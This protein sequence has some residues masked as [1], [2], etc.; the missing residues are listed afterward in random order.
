MNSKLRNK[1][2]A[3]PYSIWMT[4]FIIIPLIFVVYYGLTNDANAFTLDNVISFFNPIHLKSF[5]QAFK[6]AFISTLICIV[7]AFPI[8]LIF[9][10]SK[11]KKSSFVVYVFILPMWMNGLLRIYAWLTLI[12]KKGVINLLLTALGLPNINIV[13]TE[14]AIILGM[15]YDFLPFMILPLYNALMKIKDDTLNGARDLGANELQVFTRVIFPLSI[16]GMVSGITMVFIPALTT[17]AISYMLGGGL[18][19][20]IGNV[21]EQEFLT[22]ANWHLGSGLSLVLIIFIFIVMGI[23][24]KFTDKDEENNL[25]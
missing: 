15:V 3:A 5:M 18:F 19:L 7:L 16:P 13:N 2:V 1:L 21:I 6:L 24:N 25:I 12:E 20:L 17:V 4:G 22:T 14:T 9:R 11:T 8:A 23:T 10:N